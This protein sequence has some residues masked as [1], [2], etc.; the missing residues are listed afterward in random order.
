MES[1]AEVKRYCVHTSVELHVDC[2]PACPLGIYSGLVCVGPQALG[3][4]WA[5]AVGPILHRSRCQLCGQPLPALT[6]LGACGHEHKGFET[7]QV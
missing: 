5:I 6:E 7:R 3:L 1:V 4:S 2:F